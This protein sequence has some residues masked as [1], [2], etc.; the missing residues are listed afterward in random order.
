M[1]QAV[2]VVASFTTGVVWPAP[3]PQAA[4]VLVCFSFCGGGTV[5][6]RP[7][8][9]ALSPDVDLALVCYPGRE[10]RFN[11]PMAGTWTEL[12][13]D[14]LASVR[15]LAHRPYVLFGHSMGAWVAFEVAAAAERGGFQAPQALVVSASSPPSRAAQEKLEPPTAADPDEV[16]LDWM[17]QVGQVSELVMDD[18]GLRAFALELF[19]ADKRAGWSYEFTAG[20]TVRTPM[21]VLSGVDDPHVSDVHG[22]R[23]LAAGDYRFD[24]LAGGHFYTAEI[25][26]QLPSRIVALTS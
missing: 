1:W 11:E 10:R 14:V 18:P 20:R 12:M 9:E 26:A 4:Q 23:A 8:A 7:W 25:W 19:R 3:R 21:Q 16:L 15:S 6:F 17:R 22:W 13:D 24:E 5:A 2:R